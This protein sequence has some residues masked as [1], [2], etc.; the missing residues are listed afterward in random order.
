MDAIDRD[1][2]MKNALVVL[3]IDGCNFTM[4]KNSMIRQI[5]RVARWKMWIIFGL[6]CSPTCSVGARNI[7]ATA[8]GASERDEEKVTLI[9]EAGD[10]LRQ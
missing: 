9:S 1:E 8:D 4:Q 7:I 3:T 2:F 10:T 6:F 5:G